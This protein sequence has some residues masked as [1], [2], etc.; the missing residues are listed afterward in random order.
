[1]EPPDDDHP[2][3]ALVPARPPW[4]APLLLAE[5]FAD[6]HSWRYWRNNWYEYTGTCY[7]L[8]QEDTIRGRV[9]TFVEG[10]RHEVWEWQR[11]H[12]LGDA[13]PGVKPQ[14]TDEVVDLLRDRLLVDDRMEMP[15]MLG[16]AGRTPPLLPVAN[17]LLDLDT[18]ELRP[19]TPGWFS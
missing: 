3:G 15:A 4:S 1:D 10:R 8:R 16:A 9:R 18:L 19:H 11:R 13:F 5:R 12:G 7:V 6:R 17:G 2:R 14:L